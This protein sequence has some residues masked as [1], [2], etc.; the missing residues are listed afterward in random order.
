MEG[1]RLEGRPQAAVA[2][3]PSFA[4]AP[5]PSFAAN[6]HVRHDRARS[7]A[8]THCARRS[9]LDARQCRATVQPRTVLACVGT[10]AALVWKLDFSRSQ[11]AP[12]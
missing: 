6:A 9:L 12:S 8:P 10:F 5:P 3:V 1:R 2:L 7:L 4:V 11:H